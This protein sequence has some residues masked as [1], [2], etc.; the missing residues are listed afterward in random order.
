MYLK[1]NVGRRVFSSCAIRRRRKETLN[2]TWQ[3]AKSMQMRKFTT[4]V[5]AAGVCIK[6]VGANFTSTDKATFSLN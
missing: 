1:E 3:L 4:R 2:E 5:G 6:V